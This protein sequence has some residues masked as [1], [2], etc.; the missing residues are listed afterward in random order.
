MIKEFSHGSPGYL[1]MVRLRDLHLRQPIGL[2]LKDE[3]R[4]D[5][6]GHRHFAWIEDECIVGGLIANPVDAT[7]AKLRQ[8]WIHPDRNGRGLGSKLLAAAEDVLAAGGVRHFNLHARQNAVGFYQMN[9]YVAVGD[10]F[11]EVGR[12]HLRME[13][14]LAP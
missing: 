6:E 13:K 8:M 10:E 3:E 12:P 4:I 9:G 5:E 2:R 1:E 14:H 11:P 7:T